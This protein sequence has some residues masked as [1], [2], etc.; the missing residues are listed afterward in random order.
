[1]GNQAE[2]GRGRHLKRLVVAVP[3]TAAHQDRL[4]ARFPDLRM[5][6]VAEPSDEDLRDADALVSW[7][8]D[9]AMLAAAPQLRWLQTGG[10]GVDNLP[11]RELAARGIVPTNMS[12]VHAINISEHVLAMMLAFA[13]QLPRLLRAQTERQWRDD[14]TRDEVFELS[15][16][17]VLLIGLGDI[18]IAVGERAAAFGMRVLGVRRRAELPA[19]P[20][21]DE[22]VPSERLEEALGWADHVV[23]SVP[24][25]EGTRGAIGAAQLAAMKPGAYL[26]N[27]GRGPVVDTAAL[28]EALASG[29]LGGAGLDVVD[30]EPL[31][32]DSRL[33]GMENVVITAH[34]SGATPKYWDR[35]VEIIA[36]NIERYQAGESLVNEVD[37]EAGY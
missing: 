20:G 25:T 26:Y 11:L 16:Q 4:A 22:M 13:R 3:L 14:V 33:W 36:T 31:P 10:A 7:Q 18:G 9:A 24:L 6:M 15:G 34:T 1:M 28:V 30:P 23:V 32:P 27:V 8:F 35:A 2:T 12:G 5:E 19:P 21:I 29:R 17:T 37:L